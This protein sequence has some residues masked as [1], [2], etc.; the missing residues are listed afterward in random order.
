MKKA[1]KVVL[2]TGA[3]GV[4]GRAAAEHFAKEADATVYG[5]AGILKGWKT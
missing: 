4:I 3:Q 2:V 5:R 1:K